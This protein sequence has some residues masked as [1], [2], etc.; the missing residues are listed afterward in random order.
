MWNIGNLSSRKASSPELRISCGGAELNLSW[1]AIS[2]RT[3]RLQ[4]SGDV[5]ANNWMDLSGD[6]SATSATASK[7][8]TTLSDASQRFYRV[9]LVP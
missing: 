5:S 1:Y 3:Y 8:D 2:N 7:T 9:L 6:V 4:Y